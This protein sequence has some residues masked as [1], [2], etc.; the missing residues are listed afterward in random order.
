[1]KRFLIFLMLF[2]MIQTTK[3]QSS[4]SDTVWSKSIGSEVKAVKFSPDGQFIYAAAIGRKPMKLSTETGEILR[5]YEGLI[6]Y[7][8]HP[9][10]CLDLS[11]DGRL[12]FGAD[13]ADNS[14][15]MYIWDTETGALVHTLHSDYEE[16]QKAYYKSITVSENYIAGHVTFIISGDEYESETYI[17]DRITYEKL[18]VINTTGTSNR[19]EFS[20]TGQ[21]LAVF[22]ILGQSTTTGTLLIN[23][24]N[25]DNYHDFI[26]HTE[27]VYDISFS[28]D[29]SLLASVS[30]G[31]EIKIWDV[32]QKKLV[33]ETISDNYYLHSVGFLDNSQFVVGG[34]GFE[35]SDISIWNIENPL[36]QKKYQTSSPIDL[37]YYSKNKLLALANYQSTILLDLSKITSVSNNSK[38]DFLISPNPGN[39]SV[40]ISFHLPK[41]GK[42]QVEI[43]DLN[44]NQISLLHAGFMDAGNHNLNWLTKG[45]PTGVY[46]CRITSKSFSKTLKIILEK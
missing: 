19:V 35:T 22:K 3:S 12:L 40:N 31:G 24:E 18:K 39:N 46:F 6:Y 11:N 33:K 36:P 26:G 10:L 41:A 13:Q 25:W 27:S 8:R 21:Y 43:L 14:N 34:W 20:P 44:S 42:T 5:E 2:V 45:I 16:W 1:M 28:P 29:G 9:T 7:N 38:N 15:T 32:N 17:W 30:W 37:D 4:E 23:T